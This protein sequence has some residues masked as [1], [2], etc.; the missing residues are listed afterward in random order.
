M[1]IHNG[2]FFVGGWQEEHVLRSM[3]LFKNPV[4]YGM[5]LIMIIPLTLGLILYS[6]KWKSRVG[7]IV[8]LIIILLALVYA[9]CLGGW[10]AVL[11][12]AAFFGLLNLKLKKFIA[13]FLAGLTALVL[14]VLLFPGSDVSKRMKTVFCTN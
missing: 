7:Y 8:S 2:D 4:K 11:F 13:V 14:L 12:S 6:K 1:D 9:Y 5:Y 10:I 3:G